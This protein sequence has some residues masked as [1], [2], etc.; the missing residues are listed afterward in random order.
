MRGTSIL[1][2]VTA[3]AAGALCFAHLPMA[4]ACV[5]KELAASCLAF[6]AIIAIAARGASRA[7]S[8]Q[9]QGR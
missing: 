9:P 2:L 8:T 5:A 4:A 7:R 1:L 3:L 6:S